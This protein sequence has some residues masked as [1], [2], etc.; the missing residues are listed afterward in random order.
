MVVALDNF[1]SQAHTQAYQR[2]IPIV[3][4]YNMQAIQGLEDHGRGQDPLPCDPFMV[5]II[6][7]CK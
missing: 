3:I 2:T 7:G 5:V 1:S 4:Q 6:K